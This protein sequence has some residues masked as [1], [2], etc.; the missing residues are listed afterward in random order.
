MSFDS[1]APVVIT[2]RGGSGT[3]LLSRLMQDAALFLGNEINATEDSVEW[4]GPID[5]LASQEP[6]AR[7]FGTG[8]IAAWRAH[9]ARVLERAPAAPWS[10]SAATGSAFAE[11]EF[12]QGSVLW[13]W[14]LPETLLCLPEVFLAFPR[15][16]LL[17][18]ARHPVSLCL[19]RSH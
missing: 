16:R 8:Q 15:A 9:A 2:G 11:Q 5:A 13:G 12:A 10:A 19:R 17:H 4:S 6:G 3:R 1:L 14:K 7:V 18:L